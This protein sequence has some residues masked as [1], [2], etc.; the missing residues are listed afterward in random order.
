MF[1]QRPP[2]GLG[3][4][5]VRGDINRNPEEK[6]SLPH[7]LLESSERDENHAETETPVSV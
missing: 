5:G 1:S 7:P 4:G 6:E 2:A 3:L